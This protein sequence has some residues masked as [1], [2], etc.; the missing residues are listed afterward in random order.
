MKSLVIHRLKQILRFFFALIDKDCLRGQTRTNSLEQAVWFPKF[1]K[2]SR[3]T[4]ERMRLYDPR[5]ELRLL[6]GRSSP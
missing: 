5:G 6:S 1:G 4:L 3:Q 2:V